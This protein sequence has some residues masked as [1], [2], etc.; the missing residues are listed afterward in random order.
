[1]ASNLT[2][3]R[4][5]AIA[6]S[7][8]GA[9]LGVPPQARAAAACTLDRADGP[10]ID[11]VPF[12]QNGSGLRWNLR[13]D[14]IAFSYQSPSGYYRIATMR[15]DRSD[16]HDFPSV[17]SGVPDKHRGSPYWDPSGRFV[18][19]IAQEREWTGRRL[20]GAPDYEALPGFGRHDDLWIATADGS[21]S[22]QLTH[23]PDTTDEGIL[24]PVFSPDGKRIAWS[25]RQPGGTYVLRVAD[26]VASP[27]PHLGAIRDYRPGGA[28][29]YETGSFTTD[30]NSLLYTSDQDT[31]KFYSSQIYKLD[32]VS[33]TSTRLTSGNVYNEHPTDVET[34]NGDRIVYMST[35]GV[36][37]FPLHILPGTDWYAMDL[38]GRHAVRLS[39]MNLR[40]PG[41][42]ENFGGPRFAGTVAVGPTG[43]F[44][45]GDVQDN[46][47]KQTGSSLV[48]HLVCP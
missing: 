15:S 46:I 35:L 47:A 43:E 22:W 4:S 26:F 42:P 39:T 25:S 38:E 5:I 48:V 23:D 1:M 9:A 11:S 28:A 20:F 31:H 34:P 6:A 27:Q 10:T 14:R 18:I 41:N 21:R 13:T 7:L 3:L 2:L 16:R 45:L 44:F 37:R 30:G 17:T 36:Q 40:T 8:A 32:L 19:F 12:V 33:G 29:Y 24:I